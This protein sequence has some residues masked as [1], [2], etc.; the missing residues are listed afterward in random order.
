MM[1]NTRNVIASNLDFFAPIIIGNVL[2]P[3]ALSPSVSDMSR[4]NSLGMMIKNGLEVAI[5]FLK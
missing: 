5:F 1:I 2:Q 3:Q 4:L